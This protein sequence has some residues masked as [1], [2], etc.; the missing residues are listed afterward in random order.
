MQEPGKKEYTLV[1]L[2]DLERTFT[3]DMR[4]LRVHCRLRHAWARTIHTFQVMKQHRFR[5]GLMR[6]ICPFSFSD[7]LNKFLIFVLFN[8]FP[9]TAL[10]LLV[11][12]QEG[13]PACK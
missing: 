8:S 9:F 1:T 6:V 13:C 4:D 12:R 11:G 3:V 7:N 5:Y 10:T 2:T